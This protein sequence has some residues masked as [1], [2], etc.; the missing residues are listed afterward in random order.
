MNRD[1]A[2]FLR[3]ASISLDCPPLVEK[4][5][6]KLSAETMKEIELLKLRFCFECGAEEGYDG[7]CDSCRMVKLR[8][9]SFDEQGNIR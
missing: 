5:C 2:S 4:R 9:K 7:L 8:A 1:N 6:D 3:Q